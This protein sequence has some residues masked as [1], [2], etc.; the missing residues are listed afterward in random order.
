MTLRLFKKIR[1]RVN[2]FEISPGKFEN[3][4]TFIPRTLESEISYISA[5]GYRLRRMGYSGEVKSRKK[6]GKKKTRRSP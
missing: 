4:V 1:S 5:I 2:S 3:S 6:E